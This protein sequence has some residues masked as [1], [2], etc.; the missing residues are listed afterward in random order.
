MFEVA[1]AYEQRMGT[2]S[3]LLAPL[4]VEFVGVQGEVLDVGCGT[5]SLTFAAAEFKGV[6]K[7]VGLDAS[8]AFIEYARTCNANARVCF[9]TGNA[10]N[11]PFPDASFD[12]CISSLVISFIPDASKAVKEMRR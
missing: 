12:R 6:A 1:K 9:E 3:K 7:I 2:W 11:L 4:F 8:T 10:Q 5:G